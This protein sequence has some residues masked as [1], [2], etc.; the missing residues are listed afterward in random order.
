MVNR[1][2]NGVIHA[3]GGKH[4]SWQTHSWD[5]AIVY[6]ILAFTLPHQLIDQGILSDVN[7][8]LLQQ[9][10]I[11]FAVGWTSHLF[12]DMLTSAG[13]RL[14][15]FKKKKLAFVPKQLF[16]FRFNTGNTWETFVY[17]VTKKLNIVVGFIGLVFPILYN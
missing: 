14:F 1:V 2:I 9:L 7:G 11:G 8:A 12:S 15:C 17:R 16:G 10:M 4:R 3:T 5:I 6:S 13:V